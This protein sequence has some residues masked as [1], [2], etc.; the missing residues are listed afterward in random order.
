[1]AAP[2]SHNFRLLHTLLNRTMIPGMG[3]RIRQ[4]YA[5]YNIET[6][7]SIEFDTYIGVNPIFYK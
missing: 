5:G 1:M 6:H 7:S 4:D 2:E 3:G